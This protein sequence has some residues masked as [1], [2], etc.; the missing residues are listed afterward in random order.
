MTIKVQLDLFVQEPTT[1]WKLVDP[2]A[3]SLFENCIPFEYY[4]S[5]CHLCI[6]G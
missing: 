5:N 1:D 6:N 2:I 3:L 4:A